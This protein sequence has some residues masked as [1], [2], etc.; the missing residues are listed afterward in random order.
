MPKYKIIS[1]NKEYTGLSA[2]VPFIN[3]EGYTEDKWLVQWFKNNG[4]E[5]EEIEI[6][7]KT[8][9]KNAKKD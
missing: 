1:N 8:G 9:G 7:K 4:Y 6:S 2:G 3:G 5:V